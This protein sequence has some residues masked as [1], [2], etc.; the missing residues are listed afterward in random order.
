MP[1]LRLLDGGADLADSPGDHY[2]NN[3]DD[4]YDQRER[5][6]GAEI[7]VDVKMIKQGSERLRAGRIKKDGRAELA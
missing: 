5:A 2:E 4:T 6:H 3:T 7:A 1:C